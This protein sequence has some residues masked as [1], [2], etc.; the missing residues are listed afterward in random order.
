MVEGRIGKKCSTRSEASTGSG[1]LV[2]HP[3][4]PYGDLP[5][6]HSLHSFT[7]SLVRQTH[8][9]ISSS[10]NVANERAAGGTSMTR[11]LSI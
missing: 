4:P 3:S 11:L 9:L 2:R 6:Q 7:C 5:V 8:H 1:L 10:V